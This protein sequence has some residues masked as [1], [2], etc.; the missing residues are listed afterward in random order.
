MVDDIVFGVDGCDGRDGGAAALVEVA[1]VGE[2]GE[3]DVGGL[4]R[5]EDWRRVVVGGLRSEGAASGGEEGE[6]LGHVGRAEEVGGFRY[7]P[8]LMLEGEKEGG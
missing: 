1:P 6:W 5:L 8:L 7:W 2:L 4:P 3:G